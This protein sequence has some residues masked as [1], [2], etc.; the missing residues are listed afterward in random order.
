[1]SGSIPSSIGNLTK[2][3]FFSLT[4]NKVNGSIPSWIGNVV[5]LRVLGLRTNLLTGPIPPEIGNLV[6]LT[7]LDL[8]NNQL[9]GPIPSSIGKLTKLQD[10][11]VT[12][13]IGLNGTLTP[14]CGV[15]LY[16]VGTSLTICGCVS[17]TSPPV[18]FPPPGT[19]EACLATGTATSLQKRVLAFSQVIGSYKFTCNVDSNLNPF[20]DCLNTMAQICNSTYI[21]GNT[22]RINDCKNGV[23]SM[24]GQMSSHWILFRQSCGQWPWYGTTGSLTST[25]CASANKA[26]QANAFY[27]TSDGSKINVPSS[28]TDSINKGLWSNTV[29]AG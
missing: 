13:N 4:S 25:N 3:Q 29:L 22:I 24:V 14:N 11:G 18:V 28:L 5:N 21:A 19:P 26:L 27:I 17:A 2:L 8:S 16:A 1:L 6:N 23:D 15:K 20:Q 9:S 12:N 7:N 10:F